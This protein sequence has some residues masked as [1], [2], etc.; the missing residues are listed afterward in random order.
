M[1]NAGSMRSRKRVGD[2]DGKLE[3]LREP[4]A[5]T[6]SQPV[7]RRAG[8]MLHDDEVAAVVRAD[9][10][11][12][13]DVGMVERAGRLRFLYEPLPA[14]GIGDLLRRQDFDRDWPARSEE[15]R[16]GKEVRSGWSGSE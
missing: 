13:D 8:H 6:G 2:R 15:R 11:D 3:R 4:Q 14:F 12:G 16:V 5:V 9:V 10:E 1:D 7:Q